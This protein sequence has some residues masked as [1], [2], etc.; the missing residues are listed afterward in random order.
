M[1]L[2]SVALQVLF[3]GMRELKRLQFT[4]VDKPRIDVECAGHVLTSSVIQNAKKNPNFTIPVKYFDV[5]SLQ[6]SV[7]RLADG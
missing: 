4:A 1:I 6:G 5:V 7:A 2:T 3:W